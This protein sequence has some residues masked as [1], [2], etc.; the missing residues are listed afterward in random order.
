VT[1][2]DVQDRLQRA[3]GAAY[4]VERELGGGGMSRVFVADESALGR[5][6]VVKVLRPDLAEGLSVERFKREVRLA[7]RLQHPHV[8]PLLAAGELEGG[9]LYYTMPF[10]EGESLR[11]RLDRD[12]ALPV[13]DVVRILRDA[14]SALG[15][16]HAQGIV[17]RDIKPENILLSH[18]GV[19]VAD[20]GI[21][22]AISESVHPADGETARRSSTLT[23]AGTSL[24]TPAYMSP[25]QAAG[26]VVDHRADLYALGVVAYE[27]LSGR[28]PFEG[29]SAQQLLAAHA[30]Q[31]PEPI[32]RRRSAVPLALAMLVTRLLEKHPADRPQSADDVLRALDGI[33]DAPRGTTE[34][35]GPVAVGVGGRRRGVPVWLIAGAVGAAAGI[36][37]GMWF[38]ARGDTSA[39]S[40]Q[41]IVAT[42]GA[43]PGHELRF[44]GGQALSP[45]GA[46][47]AFVAA[48]ASGVEA[49]WIRALDEIDATRVEGT[50]GGSGPFWSPDGSALGYFA[51][52]Q[53][54]VVDLKSGTRRA[55]CSA[56]RPGGGTWSPRGTIV[57][58][59]D[60]LGMPLYKVPAAGGACTQLTHYRPGDFDH[61]RPTALP[62]GKR[63]LFSSFRGNVALAA[64]IE[65]GALTEV[66]QPG[67]EAHFVPPDMM[68]FRDASGPSGQQGAVYAQQ[69]DMNTLRPIGEPRTFFDRVIGIGGLF[70]FTAT[71]RVFVG[72]RGSGK[73]LSLLWVNRQSAIVDSI[74]LP[75]E[76]GP[77]ISSA[78][79]GVSRDGR[80]V[81]IGGLGLWLHGRDRNVAA[82]V[83]A[84]TMP[85]QGIVD[86]AWGPG[87]TLIAYATVFRGPLML[88]LYH[89]RTGRSDSLFS[90][91]RRNVRNIDWSPDGGRIAFVLSAADTV[92]R[93]E[94]WVYS[95]AERRA[96]R[97]FE[98]SGNARSPRWSPDGRWM[99]YMSD[100]SGAP[101]VY[102]RRTGDASVEVP[103]SPSGGDFP[104]WRSD[105]R[106]LYYRAPDGAV[107]AV[108]AQLGETA[109]LSR[110]RVVV[111]SPPL[112]RTTRELEV[113]PDAM[114]FVAYGRE[115]PAMFTVMTDWAAKLGE[116]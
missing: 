9:V 44:D 80:S 11:A 81:A 2:T 19:M 65:T 39:G 90:P 86:P 47:L 49:L 111:S 101:A 36:A 76:A 85:N 107:M 72:V 100:V 82:R 1:P 14:S 95:M 45:D 53:L 41:P 84:E 51:A 91:G 74:V 71:P 88:R 103:V 32:E 30:T 28:P 79:F 54:R 43:P 64:D 110:P 69:L 60:F 46:R 5:K 27:L 24:G 56:P 66:R 68:L 6:V 58:G 63:V 26:D 48:D 61:R 18:G 77:L 89:V 97:A 83:R 37:A 42:I 38:G 8:V 73:P 67:N 23:A 50:E 31:T 75:R 12:G 29:R 92:L 52:G 10:V 17:H 62:D 108:S 40:V 116:K 35:S 112:N 34:T 99:A 20:F 70:R 3:L 102:V 22:K 13:A 7:A 114:E 59:P 78:N 87:D 93:D 33:A 115:D 105:G 94:I 104:R 55:L 57:Y 25:E 4:T 96:T 98:T 109:V 15:Y 16:A 106:E 113:V 21:A